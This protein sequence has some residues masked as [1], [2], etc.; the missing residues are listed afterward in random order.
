M[1]KSKYDRLCELR[2]WMES[3][4]DSE[5]LNQLVIQKILDRVND[6]FK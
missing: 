6:T 2:Y 4:F 1:T 3:E 5:E